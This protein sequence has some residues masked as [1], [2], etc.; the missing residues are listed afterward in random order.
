VWFWVQYVDTVHQS[1]KL[2]V[3]SYRWCCAEKNDT[4]NWYGKCLFLLQNSPRLRRVN[5]RR[6]VLTDWPMKHLDQQPIGYFLDG[7]WAGTIISLNTSSFGLFA[8]DKR[9]MSVCSISQ[10]N[11]T[12]G[13][14]TQGSCRE[15][16][17]KKK[18][19]ER[20][21]QALQWYRYAFCSS[22]TF[23]SHGRLADDS[24]G[25]GKQRKISSYSKH[26]FKHEPKTQVVNKLA[27]C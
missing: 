3:W 6:W 16:G 26:H 27:V 7:H 22:G 9:A 1:D 17:V 11:Q 25:G 2:S 5:W 10:N 18:K 15:N 23:S 20:N 14:E 8:S 4:K 13:E 19:E 24:V 12:D 21:K